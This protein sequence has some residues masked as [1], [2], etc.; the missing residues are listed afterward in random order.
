MHCKMHVHLNV[1]L[2][3]LAVVAVAS[4]C[5]PFAS[6]VPATGALLAARCGDPEQDSVAGQAGELRFIYGV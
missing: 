3:V 2:L 5:T 1:R 4:I 6:A